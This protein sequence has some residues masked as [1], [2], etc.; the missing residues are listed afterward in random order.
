MMSR[1]QTLHFFFLTVILLLNIHTVFCQPKKDT[2]F[3]LR[4]ITEGEYQAIFI[5]NSQSH[6]HNE[7]IRRIKIDTFYYN[8]EIQFLKDSGNGIIHSFKFNIPMEWYSLHQY[9][10]KN[11]AY[12]P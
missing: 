8:R 2:S 9:K 4:Q 10:N 7:I 6:W 11:F 1:N 5:E 12:L 3:L